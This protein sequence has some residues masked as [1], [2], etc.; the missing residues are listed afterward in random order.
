MLKNKLHLKQL[1]LL[2]LL[3]AFL[4]QSL[5]QE[6]VII[7]EIM[8][9]SPLNEKIA[10]GS[11]YSNGEYIKLLNMGYEPVRLTGWS[12][13]GGGVTE[14]FTF[15]Q[16]TVI[17]PQEEIIVAYQYNNSGFTLNQLY[18]DFDESRVGQVLYQRKIVLSNSGE[19]LK[20]VNPA[21]V[22]KDS[23]YIDG[24]S[25]GAMPVRLT[26]ENPDNI[27]G[28]LCVS[29]QRVEAVFD[30]NGNA[31][32]DKLHWKADTVTLAGPKT[33]GSFQEMT[34]VNNPDLSLNNDPA[35]SAAG[36]SFTSSNP[37]ALPTGI[38]S[39][40]SNNNDVRMENQTCYTLPVIWFRTT[41][42]SDS[43]THFKW[44]D[45]SDSQVQLVNAASET[46]GNGFEYSTPSG[47]VKYF[48]FNPSLNI[49]F[50]NTSKE[51]LNTK[52]NMS[53]TTVMGVWAPDENSRISEDEYMF[54]FQGLY[55][56]NILFTKNKVGYTAES[57]KSELEFGNG[58]N[59]SLMYRQQAES[60]VK[61]KEQSLR[62]ASYFRAYK[63][64]KSIWGEEV[65]SII[66][67]GGSVPLTNPHDSTT[68]ST[69]HASLN[70]YHGYSPEL[71][72]FD[73]RLTNLENSIFQ[74]Y[75]AIKYG[76]S[77][78]DS[79][80]APNGK[81]IWNFADNKDFNNR[82]TGFARWDELGLY[83][84]ASTTSYEEAP[85]YSYLDNQDSYE[86]SDPGNMP[87]QNK[88]LVLGRQPASELHNGEYA[89]FGDDN[90]G[91]VL[92][93][94]IAGYTA[95]SRKWLMRT[96]MLSY[97]QDTK[98]KWKLQDLEMTD[99]NS[100]ISNL[101]KA[102]ARSTGS[103][104]TQY[105]LKGKDGYL[106]WEFGE[107]LG[108]VVVK[109]GVQNDSLMPDS[110]NYGYQFTE[111]GSVYKI[112][113]GVIA[114]NA[115]SM[116]TILPKDRIEIEKIGNYMF[117]RVNGKRKNES[118]FQITNEDDMKNPYY[119]SI[120]LSGSNELY[121]NNLQHGGFVNTGNRI[122]LSYAENKA[123]DFQNHIN[124]A[125]LMIDPEASGDFNSLRV[126][127]VSEIDTVRQKLIFSHVF[128]DVDESGS[129]IFT[130]GYKNP[131]PAQ[132]AKRNGSSIAEGQKESIEKA[133][134]NYVNVYSKGSRGSKEITVNVYLSDG[135]PYALLVFD[136]A[137]R[138]VYRK[139]FAGSSSE[140][141]T[142]IALPSSG[143]FI[144]KVVSN[145]YQ[146]NTKIITK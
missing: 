124:N 58:T 50:E 2:L 29:L 61:F 80:S 30:D 27:E 55:N 143:V 8:Y 107:I 102:S 53:Q 24:T 4:Q 128:F 132:M 15:P 108:N 83:Q 11:A 17:K 106:S 122:E 134:E 3:F 110:R 63:Q 135:A 100:Y 47:A 112:E 81:N 65:K 18:A 16:Y 71:L 78:D 19:P 36:N 46:E 126:Y 116:S 136:T 99:E 88:L 91:L 57:E 101:S 64:N 66:S 142:D 60:E 103:A 93:D 96:N 5:T 44:K 98:V 145:N 21:G 41:P 94:N 114:D 138:S 35:L 25:N 39:G 1:T 140:Q 68:F 31:V 32:T 92:D 6:Y 28:S 62:I 95:L 13:E 48:N 74:T 104:V 123:Y 115:V 33:N 117:L 45:Y 82:I 90:G 129:D 9:D 84:T 7:S 40:P 51:I 72:V 14:L 109:F 56:D 89:L 87:S 20:L 120:A 113:R 130:F 34:H 38:L 144:V 105:A 97:S 54:S 75:L 69:A 43:I 37:G 146:Y 26:A 119:A 111:T 22:T 139:D 12:L 52:N 137:G 23:I 59:K 76:I 121:M 131:P 133:E 70:A 86:D 79:Y 10:T 118:G 49:S 85:D 141:F 125:Y 67:I 127:H 42:T 73:R 77:L